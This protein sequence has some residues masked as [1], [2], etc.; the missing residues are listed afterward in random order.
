MTKKLSYLFFVLLFTYSCKSRLS[1]V[2]NNY[3]VAHMAASNFLQKED[4]PGMAISVSKN[5]RLIWSQGFGYS[6]LEAQTK[7]SPKITQFRIASISKPITALALGILI[8][9]NKVTLDSSI[10]DYLPNYPKKKYDFTL[11]QLGGHTAGIRGY[12]GNEFTQNKTLSITE[13]L[14]IFKNDTL[15]FKPQSQ[16]KYSTYGFNVLS[17]VIQTVAKVPFV[18]YTKNE[19]FAPLKMASTGLDTADTPMPNRT[20]FYVKNDAGEVVLGPSVNNEYKVAGGGFLSTSEDLIRFGNEIITPTLISSTT[21]KEL[22]TSQ[23][24]DSGEKTYYGVGFGIG[25]TKNKTPKYSHSGGGIGASTLL[26][27]YPKEQVVISILTNLSGVPIFEIGEQLE[28]IFV[29]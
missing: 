1:S 4:I 15:L 23:I 19:I 28:A 29:D 5:K 20:T 16:Y 27:M 8:D 10:Y 17:E 9:H 25:E 13:G 21:L 22:L 2:S 3:A 26:L 12:R 18:T 7:V 14:G 11:R 6:N 24:L